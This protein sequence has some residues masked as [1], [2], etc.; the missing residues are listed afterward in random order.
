M[1]TESATYPHLN[2]QRDRL[3]SWVKERFLTLRYIRLDENDGNNLVEATK[4][5]KECPHLE[6]VEIKEVWRVVRREV[7]RDGLPLPIL[8]D[9]GVGA[10]HPYAPREPRRQFV[11]RQ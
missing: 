8:Q 4:V 2:S 3:L 6:W 1:I 5:A 7:D 9:L 11:P 10:R